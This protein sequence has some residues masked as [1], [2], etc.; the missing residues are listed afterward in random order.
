M[1]AG[2]ADA[3][4]RLAGSN[5]AETA[6]A[7]A[8]VNHHHHHHHHHHRRRRR[9]HHHHHAGAWAS[10]NHHRHHHRIRSSGTLIIEARECGGELV[11]RPLV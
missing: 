6:G 7:W 10:A 3:A 9:H 11:A 4:A 5:G 1:V 2:P 8:P